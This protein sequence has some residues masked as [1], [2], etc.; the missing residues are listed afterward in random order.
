MLDRVAGRVEWGVRVRL[1]E[2]RAREALAAESRQ[3]STPSGSGTSFLLRKKQEQEALAGSRRPPA[4]RGGRGLGRP[5]R[6]RR[7]RPSAR[8]AG[9]GAGAGG[10]LFLDAASPRPRRPRRRARSRRRALRLPRRL[11]RRRGGPSPAPGRPTTSLR[12]HVERAGPGRQPG[13]PR[14]QRRLAPRHRRQSAQQGRRADPARSSSASPASISS[15]FS[16]RPSSAPRTASCP[17]RSRRRDGHP[18][19]L[20]RRRCRSG[21]AAGHGDRRRAAG[22]D[23]GGRTGGRGPVPCRAVL[24]RMPRPSSGRTPWFAGSPGS[25]PPSCPSR[26]GESAADEAAVGRED[27]APRERAGG[28]PPTR[29]RLRADDPARLRRGRPGAR[30][31]A[32]AIRRTRSP[33]SRS[34]PP[35]AGDVEKPAGDR[36]P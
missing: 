7:T 4:R 32:R 11:E 9:D 6:P 30:D 8:Q 15:T 20:R 16:S 5:R 14:H 17:R 35:G 24:R 26:F 18:L 3:S 29:A 22:A 31:R 2:A 23:P 10:K 34:P 33:L 25:S 19:S 13:R 12:T 21:G 28:G 36:S 27:R 1:D